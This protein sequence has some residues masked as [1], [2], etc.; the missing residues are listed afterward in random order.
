LKVASRNTL[1]SADVF[2]QVISD[3]SIKTVEV[4]PRVINLIEGEDWCTPLMVYLHHY[5][6]TAL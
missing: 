6:Q 3:L 1:L 5:N 2:F 4:E